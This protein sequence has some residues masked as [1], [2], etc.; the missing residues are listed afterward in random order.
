MG[1]TTARTGSRGTR[2]GVR[3]FGASVTVTVTS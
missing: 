3:G 1:Q 2:L